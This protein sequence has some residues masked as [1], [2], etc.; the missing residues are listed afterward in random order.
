LSQSSQNS[1]S[2][3]LS[4]VPQYI[5]LLLKVFTVS[6][7]QLNNLPLNTL[8]TISLSRDDDVWCEADAG[9]MCTSSTI[10]TINQCFGLIRL[11][12]QVLIALTKIASL[13]EAA[14]NMQN[15]KKH[16]TEMS[17][18]EEAARTEKSQ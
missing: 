14:F 8:P 13:N 1:K 2:A 4:D 16:T 17:S 12:V 6:C 3:S 5:Q 15:I 9:R 18:G 11:L 10:M 7:N